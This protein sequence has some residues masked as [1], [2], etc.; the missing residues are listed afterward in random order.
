MTCSKCGLPQ[1]KCKHLVSHARPTIKFITAPA[2]GLGHIYG[3]TGAV[4]RY[5]GR[6]WYAGLPKPRPDTKLEVFI[7]SL[8]G[9]KAYSGGAHLKPIAGDGD[10]TEQ[11]FNRHEGAEM[12]VDGGA[13]ES[14]R[15]PNRKYTDV[16]LSIRRNMF[17]CGVTGS[18]FPKE[19]WRPR[20]ANGR[21]QTRRFV[22]AAALPARDRILW[23]PDSRKLTSAMRQKYDVVCA[24]N[25][26][27]SHREI[28]DK[29]GLSRHSV[30]RLI[31]KMLT[32]Q[33]DARNSAPNSTK[34]TPLYRKDT[35]IL[36]TPAR[37]TLPAS[38]EE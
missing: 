1:S 24:W 27:A 8:F 35:R 22:G 9:T 32:Q 17:D 33:R 26:G 19:P 10:L 12:L 18:N 36:E 25:A 14:I 30:G 29:T 16:G 15:N 2:N 4:N 37:P 6:D 3:A 21:P 20:K 23:A 7:H 31:D 5:S 28:A 34:P 38:L 11:V 13:D